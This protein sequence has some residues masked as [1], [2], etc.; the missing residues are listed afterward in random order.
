M[1]LNRLGFFPAP[2]ENESEFRRRTEHL[3]KFG[4]ECRIAPVNVPDRPRPLNPD[5]LMEKERLL[6]LSKPA[7]FR[8][9]ISPDWI[10]C[11][12]DNYKMPL[13]TGGV[14][15]HFRE[16]YGLPW[17]SYFQLKEVFQKKDKWF[18]YPAEE[19]VSHEMCHV[20]RASL[21]SERY[22]ES[23]CYSISPSALRR[24]FG[25]ALLS[26]S[27]ANYLLLSM[28]FI[29]LGAILSLEFPGLGWLPPLTPIPFYL[30]LIYGLVRNYLIRSELKKTKS[31]LSVFFA[32]RADEVLFRLTDNEIRF[33][34]GIRP[35]RFYKWW[36][37]LPGFR[38]EWF[39]QVYP[40]KSVSQKNDPE[41]AKDND[42]T[43]D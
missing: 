15:V 10:P 43:K 9:N 33:L 41:P 32:N 14:A 29:P 6:G 20:A 26:G 17:K 25:G 31:L 4:E 38:G 1:E 37:S 28:L 22:E 42:P 23:I 3:L 27:D 21:E 5:R 7:S 24:V 8:F 2:N 39:R 19:I 12:F 36:K 13:I 34:S 35:E 11:Y 18:I 16:A 40:M 30:L